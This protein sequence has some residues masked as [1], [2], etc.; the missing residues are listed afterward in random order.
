MAEQDYAQV[1]MAMVGQT[2]VIPSG[3][4]EETA[5]EDLA[6]CGWELEAQT[7]DIKEFSF[8]WNRAPDIRSVLTRS[9]KTRR[10]LGHSY[11]H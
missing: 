11:I 2:D 6:Q 8:T 3:I 9:R 1:D 7:V 4:Q 10:T 5:K